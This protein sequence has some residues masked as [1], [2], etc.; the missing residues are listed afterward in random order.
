MATTVSPEVATYQQYID[1]EW[2]GAAD[3]ATYEVL[4]PSTEEVM[5]T[6]PAGSRADSRR[7]VAAAR[8]AFDAGEWR[9]KPQ[10]QRSQI[11]FEIVK[12]L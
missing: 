7:A 12:H 3:G 6:A 4:N 1:G 9:L 11:M 10:L 5:A 2:V 8:R